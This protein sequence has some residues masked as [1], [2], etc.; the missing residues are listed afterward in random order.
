M[1]QTKDSWFAWEIVGGREEWRK[2]ENDPFGW[3]Q[4]TVSWIGNDRRHLLWA[5]RRSSAHKN[6]VCMLARR[7]KWNFGDQ[8]N[9]HMQLRSDCIDTDTVRPS[10]VQSQKHRWQCHQ[11]CPGWWFTQQTQ[12][13]VDDGSWQYEKDIGENCQC[14]SD[15]SCVWNA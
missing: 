15:S 8:R 2:I 9:V 4:C 10:I 11:L 7:E 5:Q 14:R 13:S 1:G 3:H 6:V 12:V